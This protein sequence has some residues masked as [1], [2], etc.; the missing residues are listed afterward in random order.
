RTEESLKELIEVQK[1]ADHRMDRLEAS[2]QELAEAQRRTE[3]SVKELAQAQRRTHQALERLSERV[4]V[5][6]KERAGSVL[7]VGLI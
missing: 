4:G 2:V 1:R 5:T 3:Q 7:E 6:V